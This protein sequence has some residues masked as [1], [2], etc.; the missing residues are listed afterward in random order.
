[1]FYEHPSGLRGDGRS[2]TSTPT[3]Y[4]PAP[5]G[6]L[7]TVTITTTP[8]H[9]RPRG[10]PSARRVQQRSRTGYDEEPYTP[11]SRKLPEFTLPLLDET[12]PK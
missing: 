9:S 8:S 4:A 11:S 12:Y 7:R 1:L 6:T 2:T 5:L 3:Q 10:V